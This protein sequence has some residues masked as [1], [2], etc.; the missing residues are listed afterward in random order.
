VKSVRIE[1]L[2]GWEQAL[3]D[4]EIEAAIRLALG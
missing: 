2:E 3:S 4:E 1:L